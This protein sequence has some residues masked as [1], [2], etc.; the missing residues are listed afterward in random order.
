MRKVTLIIC[1]FIHF[2]DKG[3]FDDK[4]AKK[5]DIFFLLIWYSEGAFRGDAAQPAEIALRE[6]FRKLDGHYYSLTL[7]NIVVN[8]P[9]D[10][11]DV[12]NDADGKE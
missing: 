6:N 8:D 7:N 4:S 5:K 12:E 1:S 3:G 2:N 11:K 9:D 10:E